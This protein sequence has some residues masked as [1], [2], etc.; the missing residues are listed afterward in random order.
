MV[1]SLRTDLSGCIYRICSSAAWQLAGIWHIVCLP[2]ALMFR[3]VDMTA[4]SP[5]CSGALGFSA[6]RQVILTCGRFRR[7]FDTDK[8]GVIEALVRRGCFRWQCSAHLGFV[9]RP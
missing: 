2:K 3:I 1:S 7:G 6:A 5:E 8:V 4:W 9:G